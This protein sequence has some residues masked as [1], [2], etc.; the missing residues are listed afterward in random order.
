MMISIDKWKTLK[1]LA[2]LHEKHKKP[3]IKGF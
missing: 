3:G 1:N 2:S